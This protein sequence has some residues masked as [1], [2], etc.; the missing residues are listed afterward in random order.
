MV[1]IFY[2]LL[3]RKKKYDKFEIFSA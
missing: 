1:L 2:K 3:F